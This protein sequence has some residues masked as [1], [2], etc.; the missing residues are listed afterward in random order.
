MERGERTKLDEIKFHELRL[1]QGQ[2]I[3]EGA[4]LFGGC[5]IHEENRA[6]LI[7][8]NPPLVDLASQIQPNCVW[9]FSWKD[10]LYLL[11]CRRGQESSNGQNFC[12]WYCRERALSLFVG[13]RLRPSFYTALFF[14]ELQYRTV[15]E[16]STHLTR[17]EQF[18][19]AGISPR[20]IEW[21][22]DSKAA[23]IYARA[24]GSQ[25]F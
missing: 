8:T 16:R 15:A 4:R 21:N 6:F 10:R 13:F 19:E 25:L 2:L 1:A 18:A 24:F 20:C 17:C 14:Q 3:Q 22:R 12:G 9:H 11:G 23:P 7:L 5:N